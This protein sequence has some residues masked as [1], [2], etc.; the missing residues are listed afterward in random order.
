[1]QNLWQDVL[2]ALQIQDEEAP[3]GCK[4]QKIWDNMWA[5]IRSDVIAGLRQHVHTKRLV[6]TGIS[7][8]GALADLSYVDIKATG[9]F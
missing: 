2:W 1:M 6:I 4:V 9:D 3:A 7:L 8:G 5:R